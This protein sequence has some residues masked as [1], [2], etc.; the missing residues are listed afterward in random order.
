M[1]SQGGIRPSNNPYS[2]PVVLVKKKD[3]SWRLCIDYISL[4]DSTIKDKFPIL[5]VGE[6]LNELS[7]AKLFSKLDLRS[8]YH[9][10][11]IHEDNISKTVFR[12]L[13]GHYEFLVMPFRLTN[14]P[15]TFQG[16][17]NHTFKPY[18][19]RFILVFFWRH[20][21]LQQKSGR[22]PTLSKSY[23]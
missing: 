10:I 6:L 11:R 22:T 7:E 9:Q 2:S 19:K 18:L 21:G 16:L 23:L 13:E 4:N 1:L 14:A 12:T 8:R 20:F 5:L 3:R 15:S 17:M